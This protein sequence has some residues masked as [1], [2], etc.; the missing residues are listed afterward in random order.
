M[1]KNRIIIYINHK[2]AIITSDR[3]MCFKTDISHFLGL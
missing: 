1:I 3:D 2:S